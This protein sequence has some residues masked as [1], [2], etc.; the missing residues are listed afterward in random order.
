MRHRVKPSFAPA[1]L[2]RVGY[3]SARLLG[4]GASRSRDITC[5]PTVTATDR[6]PSGWKP[7]DS[8]YFGTTWDDA[9]KSGHS[10][11]AFDPGTRGS[12]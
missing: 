7:G 10:G 5:A 11:Q 9:H 8:A 3:S 12:R 6:A 2:P 1:P 4:T